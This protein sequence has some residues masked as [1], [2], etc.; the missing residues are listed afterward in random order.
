LERKPQAGQIVAS[1]FYSYREG[2][3]QKDHSNMLRSVLYNALDQDEAFFFHFQERY[4]QAALVGEPFRWPYNYLKEILLSLRDHPVEVRLYL[5]VDA[6]DESDDRDRLEIV[7]LLRQLCATKGPCLVKSKVF[8]ASRPITG[9]NHHAAEIANLKVITLQ[10]VNE[11]YILRFTQSFLNTNLGLSH[12]L[13]RQATEFIIQNAR[14][15][16]IW[17][18]LVK[19][20]MLKYAENGCTGK[21]IFD[22]LTSLPIELEGFYSHILAE[23]E[24]R[25]DRDITVGL[26]MLQFALFTYR[27]LRM[28]ELRHALAIPDKI[29]EEFPFSDKSFEEELIQGLDSRVIHCAGNFLDIKRVHG[30]PLYSIFSSKHFG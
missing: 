7:Q 23:L 3:S 26:R 12:D 13:V 18:H 28:Q 6:V 21:E 15:V 25:T 17:V 19:V 4:R 29:D 20:E 9:L 5:I 11:P 1:F 16:F 2:Q 30:T 8:I 10:D 24:T 22:L 14:G 27:P